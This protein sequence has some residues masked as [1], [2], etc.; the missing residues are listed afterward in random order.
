MTTYH[1]VIEND[2]VARQTIQHGD[3]L[4]KTYAA[5]QVG[6]LSQGYIEAYKT[7]Y[8]L[9]DVHDVLAHLGIG[10]ELPDEG[11]NVPK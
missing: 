3:L 1:V 11:P 7:E 6:V 8:G 9:A 10:D 4:S 2:A 5:P